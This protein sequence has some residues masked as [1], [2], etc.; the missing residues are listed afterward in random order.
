MRT[1]KLAQGVVNFF[2]G[3]FYAVFGRFLQLYLFVN[4]GVEHPLGYHSPGL[5]IERN[6]CGQQKGV[7][8]VLDI[9]VGDDFAVD[10]GHD[11]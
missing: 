6:P 7:N 10:E 4:S 9:F 5:S 8:A 2:F 11:F 1:F 3:Y